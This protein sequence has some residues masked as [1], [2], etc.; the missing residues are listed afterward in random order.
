MKTQLQETM[1]ELAERFVSA[2]ERETSPG[3]LQCWE[4]ARAL[5]D[6]ERAT[7]NLRLERVSAGLE[8]LEFVM[9]CWAT[10]GFETSFRLAGQLLESI[11]S[12]ADREAYVGESL[13]A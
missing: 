9:R 4:E 10:S 8:S 12:A 6:I 11:W 2:R 5:L 1:S 7:G 13:A 3:A